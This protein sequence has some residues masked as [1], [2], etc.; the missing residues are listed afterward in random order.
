MPELLVRET[1][2]SFEVV[3]I[4]TLSVGSYVLVQ[5]GQIRIVVPYRDRHGGDSHVDV[6]SS[7]RWVKPEVFA[8]S[9]LGTE[10]GLK[11]QAF[12]WRPCSI[13]ARQEI[14]LLRL[15][16][17]LLCS[18]YPVWISIDITSACRQLIIVGQLSVGIID[19]HDRPSMKCIEED[20]G[21][22]VSVCTRSVVDH[23]VRRNVDTD[24]NFIR[25]LIVRVHSQRESFVVRIHNHTVLSK[26]TRYY[27]GIDTVLVGGQRQ[28]VR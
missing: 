4:D 24:G 16:G 11:C 23:V 8:V 10:A 9:D 21:T 15:V 22:S 17:D 1:Q 3:I 25:E 5:P 26:D 19:R 12:D 20:T 28:V 18:S 2:Q 13:G 27:R 14:Q 7:C 6:G